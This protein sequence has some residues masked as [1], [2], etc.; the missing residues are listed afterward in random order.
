MTTQ[1]QKRDENSRKALEK[2]RCDTCDK[3]LTLGVYTTIRDDNLM[4]E[5]SKQKCYNVCLAFA[6]EM[7]AEIGTFTGLGCEEWEQRSE[8]Q[9]KMKKKS[10]KTMQERLF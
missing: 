4:G 3:Q 2:L 9:D 6:D 10:E 7:I 8:Y 5:L 1:E